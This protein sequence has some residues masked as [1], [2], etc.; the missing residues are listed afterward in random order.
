L[1]GERQ[2]E[3]EQFHRLYINGTSYTYTGLNSSKSAYT[4]GFVIPITATLKRCY[5]V[6]YGLIAD[7]PLDDGETDTSTSVVDDESTVDN[8]GVTVNFPDWV[9]GPHGDNC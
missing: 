7:W 5:V 6:N 9:G 8:D 2:G 1:N 3:I 4:A